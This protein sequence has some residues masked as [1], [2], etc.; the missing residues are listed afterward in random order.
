MQSAGHGE[1]VPLV[2]VIL[3]T[4]DAVTKVCIAVIVPSPGIVARHVD[5]VGGGVAVTVHVAHINRVDKPLVHQWRLEM[6]NITSSK[7]SNS[8][9]YLPVSVSFEPVSC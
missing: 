5:E 4:P 3:R 7:S 6:T 1:L 8:S 2:S 9:P